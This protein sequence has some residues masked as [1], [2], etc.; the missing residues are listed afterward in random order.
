MPTSEP[1]KDWILENIRNIMHEKHI[2][3]E[4]ISSAI[5][6]S[7][8]ELSKILNG[9]RK[10]YF[11]HLPNIAKVLEVSFHQLVTPQNG[12]VFNNHGSIDTIG[13]AQAHIVEQKDESIKIYCTKRI[14]LLN[15]IINI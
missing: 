9:E 6:I 1:N 2:K 12:N 7:N 11:K 3:V 10:D 14:M 4:N 8:G 5:G 15:Q 13:V